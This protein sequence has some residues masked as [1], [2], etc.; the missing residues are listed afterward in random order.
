MHKHI[1]GPTLSALVLVTA[2]SGCAGS[3]STSTSTSAAAP[4]TASPTATV[5]VTAGS[6]TVTVGLNE[7]AQLGPLSYLVSQV[8]DLGNTLES[9]EG[10]SITNGT[11]VAATVRAQNSAAAPYRLDPT[12]FTATT[13]GGDTIKGNLNDSIVANGNDPA[14]NRP[15]ANGAV[16]VGQVVFNFPKPPKGE[17]SKITIRDSSGGTVIVTV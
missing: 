3:S 1:L 13:S 7:A 14:F 17:V 2:V 15:I 6:S 16:V 8:S 5:T 12:D 4:T 10:G 9:P 11:F